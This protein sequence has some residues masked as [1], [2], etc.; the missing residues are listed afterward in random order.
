[1]CIY[2]VDNYSGNFMLM[3]IFILIKRYYFQ[4]SIILY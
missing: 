1:M 3:L 2:Y 4:Q